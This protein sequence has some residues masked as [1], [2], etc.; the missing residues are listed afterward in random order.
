[1]KSIKEYVKGRYLVIKGARVA[2]AVL[3]AAQAKPQAREYIRRFEVRINPCTTVTR[4]K[5]YN[6]AGKVVGWYNAAGKV[7]GWYC[8]EDLRAMHARYTELL[9]LSL[10]PGVAEDIARRIATIEDVLPD[11]VVPPRPL[12]RGQP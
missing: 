1:M 12:Y 5:W 7:V 6:A 9:Q 4:Y 11:E 8:E 10:A 2:K 3:V